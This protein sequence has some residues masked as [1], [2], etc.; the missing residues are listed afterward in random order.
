MTNP[1][2]LKGLALPLAVA[3]VVA[4][5]AAFAGNVEVKPSFDIATMYL[6]RGLN[7]G[8]GTDVC[9]QPQVSGGLQASKDGAYLGIWATSASAGEYDLYTGYA[10]NITDKLKVDLSVWNYIYTGRLD[11]S[12]GQTS[13]RNFGNYSEA[14]LTT[15]YSD[16]WL[17]IARN[18]AGGPADIND[19]GAMYYSTGVNIDKVSLSLGYQDYKSSNDPNPNYIH[20]DATYAY[21]EQ[22]SLTFSQILKQ[23]SYVDG[24][25][26]KHDDVY[27][28][29]LKYVVT[30]HVPFK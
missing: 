28:N 5:G 10:Y 3:S 9:S 11:S 15:S 25:G 17:T 29:N 2:S 13:A 8:C 6:Y 7:S 23:D 1:F 19:E 27:N 18:V 21:N 26:I 12:E 22:L 20:F 4:S 30:Y 24:D 16:V 14:F